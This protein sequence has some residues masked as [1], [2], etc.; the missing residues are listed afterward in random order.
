MPVEVEPSRTLFY[1]PDPIFP[2]VGGDEVAARIAHIR[3]LEVADELGNVAAHPVLVRRLVARFMDSGIDRA[4][5][6]FEEGAVEPVVDIGN[7]EIPVRRDGGTHVNKPPR[8]PDILIYIVIVAA[9]N[10]TLGRRSRR[11][12][13]SAVRTCKRHCHISS[14]QVRAPYRAAN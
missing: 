1:R 7:N 9:T 4:S 3:N 2:V 8:K 6:V 14:V 10:L 11:N 13:A 12:I 5:Q